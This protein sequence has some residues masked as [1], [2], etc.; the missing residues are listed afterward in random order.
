V[1]PL[2]SFLRWIPY[3]RDIVLLFGP[4]VEMAKSQNHHPE[5]TKKAE[6][7][8]SPALGLWSPIMIAFYD[9]QWGQWD[10]SKEHPRPTG[11]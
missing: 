1:D 4:V 8:M 3:L 7:L 9:P 11:G 2:C 5:R 10:Y 6:R